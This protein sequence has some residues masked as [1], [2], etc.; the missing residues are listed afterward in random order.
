MRFDYLQNFLKKMSI[1]VEE[2]LDCLE[3]AIGKLQTS[4]DASIELMM[5][6]FDMSFYYILARP[7]SDC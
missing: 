7:N 4:V 5:P 3:V 2:R 6:V 1:S